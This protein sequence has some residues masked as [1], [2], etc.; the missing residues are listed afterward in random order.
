ML[1]EWI[2]GFIL[3]ASALGVI[4]ARQPVYA[5][6]SF[7]LSL[8]TLGVIYL[9]EFA[10]FIAVLQVL[11]YAGAILV[12]F[13][14][15]IVLFQDAHEQLSITKPQASLP[16]I[17]LAALA[18]LSAFSVVGYKLIGYQK[19]VAEIPAGFG[20]V[21]ALGHSLYLDYFF[22][23]EAVVFLFLIA[24]VGSVYLAKRLI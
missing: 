14:F 1:V 2:L 12:I 11:V 19:Q 7:L 13:I 5:A 6:L 24:L 9:Q 21:Q 18:I 22:P 16:L 20:S 3:I 23:F 15:V 8:F 4:L 10:E 17:T